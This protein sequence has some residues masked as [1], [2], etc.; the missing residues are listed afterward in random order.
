MGEPNPFPDRNPRRRIA[1]RGSAQRRGFSRRPP[2]PD[3]RNRGPVQPR[4]VVSHSRVRPIMGPAASRE[5]ETA[6]GMAMKVGVI[7]FPGSN[8][9][10]DAKVALEE[11]LDATVDLI[12]HRA[13]ALTGYDALVLPGGFAHGD[14]LRTGAIARFSPVMAAV[15]RFAA[16]GGPVLGI[17]NGFQILCEAGLLPGVAA[18]Q[19][20]PALHLPL[21]PRRR[22][23][24]RYALDGRPRAGR[25]PAPADRPRRRTLFRRPGD[26]GGADDQRPGR[27]ALLRP[28]RRRRRGGQPERLARQHRRRLQRRRQ[29]R[30]HD[31]APRARRRPDPRR[32]RRPAGAGLAAGGGAGGAL[33]EWSV[34]SGQ[35]PLATLSSDG[36]PL[37]AIAKGRLRELTTD[38]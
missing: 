25:P 32:R 26:A 6:G 21:G 13:T 34:V 22:R 37:W 30:R 12:W 19:R 38:H 15:E 28:G 27:A 1:W 24:R 36:R 8:G 23:A 18:A 5:R 31:A 10:H 4:T 2:P 29:R 7:V 35:F 17:C 33:D 14:Y 3:A 16:A 9:D 11:T 20:Q